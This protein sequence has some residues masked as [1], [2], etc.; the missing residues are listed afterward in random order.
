[1]LW[2][3]F[4]FF[5]LSVSSSDESTGDLDDDGGW[6]I[7]PQLYHWVMV[8]CKR[9]FPIWLNECK[10]RESER[11]TWDFGINTIIGYENKRIARWNALGADTSSI[12]C[13]VWNT[14]FW[15][16]G[17]KCKEATTITTT[18]NCIMRFF[19]DVYSYTILSI[20]CDLVCME[21]D[22]FFLLSV[23]ISFSMGER[24]NTR[25]KKVP[26]LITWTEKKEDLNACRHMPFKSTAS[27]TRYFLSVHSFFFQYCYFLHSISR[28]K[29]IPFEIRLKRKTFFA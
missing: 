23:R 19:S 25:K 18:T 7:R 13:S 1:M 20:C 29:K 28:R 2:F 11:N 6:C 15:Y 4:F 12:I 17:S 10:E 3:C 26:W 5:F 16:F 24:N 8:K 14:Y 27:F 22:V 21:P 9:N